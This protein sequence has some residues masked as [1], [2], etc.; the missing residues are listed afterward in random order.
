MDT[1]TPQLTSVQMFCQLSEDCA[2]GLIGSSVEFYA[3]QVACRQQYEKEVRERHTREAQHNPLKCWLCV[4]ERNKA[5]DE[6]VVVRPKAKGERV[7][8][9]A[10]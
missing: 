1:Q 2:K 10:I 8:G 4:E 3:R 9:I 6:S 7:R 5:M